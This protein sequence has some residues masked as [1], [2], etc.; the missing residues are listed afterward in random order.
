MSRG[1]FFYNECEEQ[2][3]RQEAY[4][5]DSCYLCARPFMSDSDMYM[6]K[7]NTP[8]CS[9]DC[10]EE[11]IEFDKAREQKKKKKKQQSVRQSDSDQ[12]C[13]SSDVRQGGI[14]VA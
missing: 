4:V 5:F 2:G 6:Y 3:C 1:L 13:P 9:E 8:F 7:G 11:Q 10:R 14:Q 12:S